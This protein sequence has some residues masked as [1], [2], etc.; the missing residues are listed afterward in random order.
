MGGIIYSGA[1]CVHFLGGFRH[2]GHGGGI[3]D[4]ADRGAGGCSA[5]AAVSVAHAKG[6]DFGGKAG[7]RPA[8]SR[9]RVP[10][11]WSAVVDAGLAMLVPGLRGCKELGAKARVSR[12]GRDKSLPALHPPLSS[13]YTP[14]LFRR[15]FQGAP[16]LRL[17][18]CISLRRRSTR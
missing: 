17:R 8:C 6:A 2:A 1:R 4:W 18:R 11:L 14:R 16:L 10:V 15:S 7:N 3:L 13:F 12:P 9:Y 5:T